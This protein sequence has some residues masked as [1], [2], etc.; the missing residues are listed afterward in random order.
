MYLVMV[1]F[2]VN[3][4]NNWSLFR[5]QEETKLVFGS[6][7]ADI[8]SLATLP[9]SAGPDRFIRGYNKRR[10]SQTRNRFETNIWQVQS[11]SWKIKIANMFFRDLYEVACSQSWVN[12]LS[13]V[14][15]NKVNTNTESKKTKLKQDK[16]IDE[17][18][19]H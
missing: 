15:Y 9:V 8:H 16:I 4:C 10:L 14:L 18:I 6:D 7:I 17:I 5:L 13:C 2:R 12:K 3:L 11:I 1:R 19:V